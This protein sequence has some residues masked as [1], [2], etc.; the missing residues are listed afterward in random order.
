MN[1]WN[2]P[3]STIPREKYA[4]MEETFDAW[5]DKAEELAGDRAEFVRR[6]R[7]QWRYIKLML[8]P[9]PEEGKRFMETLE[10]E[11]VQMTEW[12]GNDWTRIH[13]DLKESFPQKEDA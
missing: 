13:D 9:D 6:S 1:I 8:H 12:W 2:P 10:K 5:W 7:L 11:K 4:A 3:F